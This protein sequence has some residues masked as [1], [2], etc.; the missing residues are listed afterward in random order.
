MEFTWNQFSMVTQGHRSK[1]KTV[2]PF[3]P[4]L[5]RVLMKLIPKPFT[6]FLACVACTLIADVQAEEWLQWRGPARTGVV[7]N[8]NW[9]DTLAAGELDSGW[10]V[11]LGPGYSGPLVTE[12]RV[13]VTETRGQKDEVVRALDR[14]T[15][16]EVWAVDWA[17]SM[18]VP[19]FAAANGSWIRSTPTLD[20][21]DLFVA[22]IR[23]VLVCLNAETGEV[24]WKVDL[25]KDTGASL[26]SFGC[27]CSPLVDEGHVYM[28]AG[29]GFV[30]L[31]R[32]DGGIVWR[33]VG[34][35]GGMFGSAFSSPVIA[36]IAG[37]RQ[38][39]VQ[40]RKQ[41]CGVDLQRGKVLWSQDIEAFRGMNILT[42]TVIGNRVFTSS[43]GGGSFLFEVTGSVEDG[44]KASQ[45]W[46]NKVQAYMSSPVVID[47]FVYLHLRNQRFACIDLETGKEAW[48]TTPFG[49]YW[50]LIAAG[51]RILALD[52]RG[53]LL[54]IRANP[55]KFDLI[56]RREI[57]TRPTWAHVAV[58]GD[59]V[60]VRELEAIS[61]FNWKQAAKGSSSDSSA[62][63]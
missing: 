47:G 15:G 45:L 23:D 25:V 7:S 27:V 55:E 38:A 63:E 36:T 30:K 6:F 60:F 3:D 19:F 21:D 8:Q 29:G 43:Y 4:N 51:D 46:R 57:S 48:I 33:S 26:P 17:G 5:R 32:T 1:I 58:A 18:S 16:E 2:T 39:V 37:L 40:T 54:L 20:G 61:V 28:Q 41:L 35:G 31:D 14:T 22:G 34:D 44:F 59:Q 56:D 9:P 62:A 49:K 10:R 11:K 12:D 53:E 50:S 52:E 24:K 13:Y 42:P